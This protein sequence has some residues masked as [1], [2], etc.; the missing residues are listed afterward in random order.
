MTRS[1]AQ[2]KQMARGTLQGRWGL[3]IGACFLISLISGGSTTYITLT[4]RGYNAAAS[5]IQKFLM[6]DGIALI[7]ALIGSVFSAGL[8]FLFLNIC[9]GKKHSL[10]D[11][12]YAFKH[13]PDRYIFASL[14]LMIIAFA[15]MIPTIIYTGV[16]IV[17]GQETSSL[18]LMSVFS[19][20]GSILSV[21]LSL[22]YGIV[23]EL[24]LDHEDLKLFAAFKESA[25]LMRGNKGRLF[26]IQL[27][28]LGWAFLSIFTCYIGLLWLMP[29]MQMTAAYFYL[30]V[31]GE[32]DGGGNV[33]DPMGQNPT[34]YFN[35]NMDQSYNPYTNN[36]MDTNYYPNTTEDT[37]NDTNTSDDLK[38]SDD[39]IYDNS[40]ESIT[41][42]SDSTTN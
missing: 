8:I 15:P 12:L 17:S 36:T 23:I 16:S 20:V 26:Y 2:L 34:E 22:R 28:F 9:R 25:R 4:N 41:N 21:I 32:L 7:F 35:P 37:K 6:L 13:H 30:D 10:S 33:T 18:L 11:L 19:I 14:I 38:V 1:S 24:L 39:S 5:S 29:Y 27:S 3:P 42:D 31:V 40:Q